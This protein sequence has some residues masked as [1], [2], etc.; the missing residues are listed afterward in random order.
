MVVAMH[1]RSRDAKNCYIL[2]ETVRLAFD[3]SKGAAH[4]TNTTGGYVNDRAASAPVRAPAAPAPAPRIKIRIRT[5]TKTETKACAR[6][7]T[8]TRIRAKTRTRIGQGLG[9]GH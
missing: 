2:K 8:R 7:R 6:I 3:S 1:G 4:S 9:P 5:R